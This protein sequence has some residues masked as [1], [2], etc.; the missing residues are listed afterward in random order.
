MLNVVRVIVPLGIHAFNRRVTIR[1][2]GVSQSG[3]D[4]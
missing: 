1:P 3:G 4:A 2:M